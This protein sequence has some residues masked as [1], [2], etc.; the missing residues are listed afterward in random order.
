VKISREL[1]HSVFAKMRCDQLKRVA[2]SDKYVVMLGNMLLQ[3]LGNRRSNDISARMREV[4]RLLTHIAA[5]DG[6]Q[7]KLSELLDG[8]NFDRVVSAIEEIAGFTVNEDGRRVCKSPAF[9]TR[10]TGSLLKC[11]LLKQGQALRD[12]DDAAFAEAKNF[13]KLHRSE[14]TDRVVSAA[15]TSYR[16]KGNTLSEYP[17]EADFKKLKE[18]TDNNITRLT[19]ELPRNPNADLWRELAELTLARILVF[20]ARRGAAVA[21]LTIEQFNKASSEVDPELSACFTAVEQQ[22]IGRYVVFCCTQWHNITLAADALN[23]PQEIR[24]N[25]PQEVHCQALAADGLNSTQIVGL[26]SPQ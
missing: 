5:A 26:K 8:S 21:D 2:A 7:V 16:V 12:S 15:H 20:N 4:A 23:S 25:S 18:Y 1:K 13:I 9:V 17:D 24:L 22:L 6:K 3:R 11:A 19:Q 14:L 10:V